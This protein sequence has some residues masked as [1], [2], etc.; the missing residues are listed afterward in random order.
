MDADKAWLNHIRT[1]IDAFEA[2]VAVLLTLPWKR[3]AD[4]Q[5]EWAAGTYRRFLVLTI[6]D[7]CTGPGELSIAYYEEHGWVWA[8]YTL[9]GEWPPRII[10]EV[11]A[12]LDVT[13]AELGELANQLH[14]LSDLAPPA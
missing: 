14:G 1:E 2:R 7:G 10:G 6:P 11:V 13:P 8:G 5:P 9:A 12:W 3:T 4:G